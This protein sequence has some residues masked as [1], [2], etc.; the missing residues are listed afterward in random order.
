MRV[1]VIMPLGNAGSAASDAVPSLAALHDWRRRGQRIIVAGAEAG[2]GLGALADRIVYAPGGWA[3]QANAGSRAPEA[4]LVDALV[5][6]P[7]GVLLPPD[8]DRAILRALAN[9]SSPWGRFDIRYPPAPRAAL[10]CA[11]DAA[12]ANA[13][14]RLTGIC[15][16]E[17]AI[18]VTRGAFLALEGY[19]PLDPAAQPA[20]DAVAEMDF[21]HRARLLGAPILLHAPARVARP[22]AGAAAVLRAAARR[23]GWRLAHALG[24]GAWAVRTAPL[25]GA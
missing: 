24:L 11:A 23:E 12:L 15:T 22:A 8:G 21:C 14:S 4:E 16:R 20:A 7:P 25:H 1:A 5:F 17:Q 13:G 9:A 18:F 2:A 3:R 19:A 6:L 10:A